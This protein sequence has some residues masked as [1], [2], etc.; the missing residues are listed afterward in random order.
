MIKGKNIV[1]V[2]IQSWDIPIGSNLKHCNRT[3]NN[4]VIYVN[5]PLDRKII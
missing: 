4:N 3:Q 1:I 2:G 5:V